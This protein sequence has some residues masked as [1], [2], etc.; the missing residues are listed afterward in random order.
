M[1]G[2]KARIDKLYSGSVSSVTSKITVMKNDEIIKQKVI[3]N[4]KEKVIQIIVKL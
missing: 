2:L 1:A 4:N 3:G